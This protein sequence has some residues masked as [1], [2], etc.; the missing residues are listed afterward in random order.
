MQHKQMHR[1]IFGEHPQMFPSVRTKVVNFFTVTVVNKFSVNAG[2]LFGCHCFETGKLIR[3]H[4]GK[5]IQCHMVNFFIDIHMHSVCA[6]L[7]GNMPHNITHLI[8][9]LLRHH[10]ERIKRAPSSR[11]SRKSSLSVPSF[12]L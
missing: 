10:K 3:C 8:H 5:L 11:W 2:K 7:Q 4:N 12:K 6:R 9:S 1:Y